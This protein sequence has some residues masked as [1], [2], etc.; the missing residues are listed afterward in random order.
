MAAAVTPLQ[1]PLS[2]C[3]VRDV[4]VLLPSP[5]SEG[6]IW[7]ASDGA[8][9]LL[10]PKAQGAAGAVLGAPARRGHTRNA[11]LCC[12]DASWHTQPAIYLHTGGRTP[13]WPRMVWGPAG[14]GSSSAPMALYTLPV[15]CPPAE[16]HDVPM[17]AWGPAVGG[18]K[19]PPTVGHRELGSPFGPILCWVSPKAST[20]QD[21]TRA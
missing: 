6:A 3:R 16:H 13:I 17:A 19:H 18:H 12:P 4:A 10:A 15:H 14:W 9:Q 5:V 20:Q 8:G 21:C 11:A 2:A 7:A 1:H